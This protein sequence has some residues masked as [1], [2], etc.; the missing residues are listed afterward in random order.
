M[1]IAL[2]VM[3]LVVGTVGLWFWTNMNYDRNDQRVLARAGFIEKQVT[4]ANGTVLN[5]G[6]GPAAGPPLLLIHGQQTS[7]TSYVRVLPELAR[8]FHVF[9]VDKHG[10]GGSSKDPDKYSARAMGADL[11]TFIEQVIGQP[12]YLSGHSSGALLSV[13]LAANSAA[14][15]RAVVLEDP[16]LFATEPG[17]AEDTFAWR[18][19]F[20]NIHNFLQQ[21]QQSDYTRYYLEHSELRGF[22]GSGWD[23]IVRYANRFLDRNPGRRL[24]IFFLPASLNRAF[25]LLDG[26]YDLRFGDTFYDFSWFEGFNQAAAL[27]AVTAPTTLIHASWRY[28]D[29]GVLLAAMDGEDAARAMDLLRDG[30]LVNIKSGHNVHGE[31]PRQFVAVLLKAFGRESS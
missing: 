2:F 26:D 23:G 31:K 8:H 3:L 10:H 15:V 17:R 6:E 20:R 9:A 14:L 27:A 13:W 22:F 25:D 30:M 16:P 7:W 28:S 11:A 19:S 5:Y 18:D 4:L 24:R 1:W 21:D 29:D 12:V